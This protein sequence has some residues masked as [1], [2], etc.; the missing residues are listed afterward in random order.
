M[1]KMKKHLI[2]TRKEKSLKYVQVLYWHRTKYLLRS[3]DIMQN[4]YSEVW[5]YLLEQINNTMKIWNKP[6]YMHLKCF[7]GKQSNI[8]MFRK[9]S[10]DKTFR[11]ANS[12][13]VASDL[14]QTTPSYA[15]TSSWCSTHYL[16]HSLE[17]KCF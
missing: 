17:R 12:L 8:F 14:Q 1:L 15:L 11:S 5:T 6:L 2:K 13:F 9:R 3:T 16:D 4:I 7:L 10:S